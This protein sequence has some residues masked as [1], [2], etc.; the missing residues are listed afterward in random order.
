MTWRAGAFVFGVCCALAACDDDG[1]VGGDAGA[2]PLDGGDPA[3]IDAQFARS[4]GPVAACRSGTPATIP[5]LCTS[6]PRGT[7]TGDSWIVCAVSP[8]GQAYSL[9]IRADQWISSPGWTHAWYG[10][11]DG[12]LSAQGVAACAQEGPSRM[13]GA[14]SSVLPDAGDALCYRR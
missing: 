5:E 3:L 12:T 6:T 9:R 13:D 10:A 1:D 14:D 11:I 2:Q 7:A 4:C 8:D